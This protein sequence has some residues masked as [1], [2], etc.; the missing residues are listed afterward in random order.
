[1]K[2]ISRQEFDYLIKKRKLEDPKKIKAFEKILKD[3]R[4]YVFKMPKRGSNVILMASGGLDSMVVWGILMKEYGLNV[5]PITF[6]RGEKKRNR[7]F[8]AFKYF[9]KFY[10]KKFPKNYRKFLDLDVGQDQISIKIE[11]GVKDLREET[12][13][14]NFRDDLMFF[15]PSLGVFTILPLFARSYA[16]Y[17]N[18]IKGLK[19]NTIF[20]AV[21]ANDGELIAHQTLTS[22]R[23]IM[24]NMCVSIKD[25]SW[26]FLSIC[27]EPEINSFIKKSDLVKW[28]EDNSL[29]LEKSWSCYHAKKYQCGGDNCIACEARRKAYLE[30]KIEDRTIYKSLADQE[31]LIKKAKKTLRKYLSRTKKNLINTVKRFF[32]DTIR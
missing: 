21:T 4:G 18:A 8:A 31:I 23:S 1:M 11:D 19:I 2:K 16:M 32:E 25:Y 9:D 30:A 7:E 27:L 20:C 26:Q 29:P 13:L 24:C 6:D 17:L 14:N 3:E 5:Y 22:L 10:Q 12:L 28:G 15:N